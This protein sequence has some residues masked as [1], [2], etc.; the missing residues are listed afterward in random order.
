MLRIIS[1]I[2]HLL[3]VIFYKLK[4][5]CLPGEKIQNSI[6]KD[7]KKKPINT[8]RKDTKIQNPFK[9]RVSWN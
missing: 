3:L 8:L 5:F 6:D 9:K 1:K 2:K 7:K 4:L